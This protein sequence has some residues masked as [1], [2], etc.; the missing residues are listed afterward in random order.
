MPT[1]LDLE[2]LSA[3]LRAHKDYTRAV[4]SERDALRKELAELR[5]QVISDIGQEIDAKAEPVQEPVLWINDEDAVEYNRKDWMS[6]DVWT[7]LY[8]AAPQDGLRKAAQMALDTLQYL[9][10]DMT[11]HE[12]DIVND[13]IK[14]LR[15]ELGHD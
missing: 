8:A 14:A 5:L 12:N 7:P 6:D 4:I 11:D 2:N 1:N 9:Y 10:S 3:N 15:K 13:S